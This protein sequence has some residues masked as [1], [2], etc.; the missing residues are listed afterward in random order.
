[1]GPGAPLL[2][3]FQG[4]TEPSALCLP[5]YYRMAALVYY[6]F[7]MRPDDIVY[8]CLPLY[9]S[10]G[11][12]GPPPWCPAVPEPSEPYPSWQATCCSRN[13][14]SLE[15][16]LVSKPDMDIDLDESGHTSII[17]GCGSAH[18]APGLV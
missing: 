12:L 17:G 4:P 16:N 15:S 7:R 9:H 3:P 1:M 5:R 10:A 2:L 14:T 11:S 6:G 13:I 18:R 8:D